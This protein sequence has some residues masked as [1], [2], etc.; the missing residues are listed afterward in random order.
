VK[1]NESIQGYYNKIIEGLEALSFGKL[2][3][4][5]IESKYM[6]LKQLS[7]GFMTLRGDDSSKVEVEFPEN[8]KLDALQELIET[9]PPDSKMIVFHDFRYT[10]GL[11]SKR[12]T[13]MKIPHASVWGGAKKPLKELRKFKKDPK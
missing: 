2:K 5:E 4:R 13:K 11:I 8:P 1:S 3:Y 12:L 7:S 10:N 6:K 9:M